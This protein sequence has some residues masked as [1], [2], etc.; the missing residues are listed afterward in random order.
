MV[1]TTSH[2]YSCRCHLN[3][4]TCVSIQGIKYLYKYVYK[5]GDRCMAWAKLR[6]EQGKNAEHELEMYEDLR[7]IGSAEGCWKTFDL[8]MYSRY[9]AVERLDI[10]LE[11]DQNCNF[12]DGA[13]R[14]VV[15]AGPPQTTLTAWFDHIKHGRDE[16]S[17]TPSDGRGRM[18]PWSA[19]YPDFVERYR[20]VQQSKTWRLRT[21]GCCNGSIIGRVRNVHPS[22]GPLFY[23]RMLLHH[24]PA[25]ELSL[26]AS[27]ASPDD[28]ECDAYSYEALKYFGQRKHDTFKDACAARGLLQ[29]DGE[30][31]SALE[32][33]AGVCMPPAIRALFGY[34]LTFNEPEDPASLFDDFWQKMGEDYARDLS[35]RG[36]GTDAVVRALVL[37]DIE[38]RIQGGGKQLTDFNLSLSEADRALAEQVRA[39]T[40]QAN[41]PKEIRDELIPPPE[42]AQLAESATMRLATLKPSQR[43]AYY[44]VL[45]AV[46]CPKGQRIFFDAPGGTGKTYTFNTI[47]AALR[48]KGIIVLA[49]A[50]SGIAAILLELG[51]TFH[52]RFKCERLHPAANQTLNI[53]AQTAL[54]EL[55]RRCH[56]I[57][58]DEAAMGNKYHLEALDKTLRDF[59]DSNV[60]F[61][62]KTIVL[63]GDFRQTLPIVRFASRAQI[64]Q[65]ALT[66]SP[67]WAEFKSF[68]FEENMRIEGAR[69]QLQRTGGVEVDAAQTLDRLEHFA[70]WLLR[71]GDG[72]EPTD[73]LSRVALPP[74][75]CMPEGCDIDALVAWVYP[76]LAANCSSTEW[77]SGRAILTPYNKDVTTINDKVS[78]AFPGEEW[79]CKSADKT[80]D[81]DDD[82]AAPAEVLNVINPN[83]LPAHEICLKPNMPIMLLRNLDPNKGL[84]NG[85]RLLVRRVIQGR[86]LEAE[87]ATGA[88][89][90]DIVFL[91]RIKLSPDEGVYPWP[92]SRLQFPVRVAFAMTINKA[93]GQTL[94]R[95]GVYLERPCFS[96]GQL[97]V[98]ASRVGMPDHIRFAV[99]PDEDGEFRTANVVFHEALIH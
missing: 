85:T 13:E 76:N 24:V 79:I 58:W 33:A 4:E 98:A 91:P 50:S 80:T 60:P 23:M 42:R 31:R 65:V 89:C 64:L 11:G 63:G 44:A 46:A 83:G 93:Q 43:A 57:F 8:P 94:S 53:S 73:E 3:V 68:K 7:S 82:A 88:H 72:A 90:G 32:D 47:L 21:R 10:H 52:S 20:Y 67:L 41:E 69:E 22:E 48:A 19:K 96:H 36:T 56:A 70:K 81:P 15:N 99:A 55:L 26:T 39:A 30:W 16:H 54:A 75:C 92:W 95:V 27:S 12:E 51:R 14:E 71:L 38:Q 62:G 5:G 49:V 35:T 29:D 59:M 17:R 18:R 66:N 84:C 97:Y 45:A 78:A 2:V 28:I 87:I 34:I 74:E 77:L 25:S 1:I 6:K 40:V 37:F 9:P 86:L 61:G